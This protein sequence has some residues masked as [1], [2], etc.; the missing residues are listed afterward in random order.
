M[1]E[2]TDEDPETHYWV[3]LYDEKPVGNVG[4]GRFGEPYR[5]FGLDPKDWA[6]GYFQV[7]SA[8][9]GKGQGRRLLEFAEGEA[10]KR[11]VKTLWIDTTDRPDQATAYAL[12][13]K[14]GY[15]LRLIRD[16]PEF[17]CKLRVLAKE[18]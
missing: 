3:L 14:C 4:L 7:Q 18:L 16:L 9:R 12:Y 6:L 15:E 10:R 17:G 5:R 1:D 8:H 2:L 11:G 13:T